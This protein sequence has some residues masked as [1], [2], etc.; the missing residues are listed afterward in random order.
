M[1]IAKH[2]QLLADALL[3]GAA[4]EVLLAKLK[5]SQAGAILL[6]MSSTPCDPAQSS[7]QPVFRRTIRWR[8]PFALSKDSIGARDYSELCMGRVAGVLL[9]RILFPSVSPQLHLI[10]SH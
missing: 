6:T 5:R 3:K 10:G 7:R 8:S 2:K 9:I 4:S 1:K